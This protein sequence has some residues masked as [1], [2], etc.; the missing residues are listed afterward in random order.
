MTCTPVSFTYTFEPLPTGWVNL[1]EVDDVLRIENCP[2][3]FVAGGIPSKETGSHYA[4]ADLSSFANK[5]PGYGKTVFVGE[6]LAVRVGAMNQPSL[7]KYIRT[8]GAAA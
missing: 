3:I 8:N 5:I 4:T 1:Y 6:E 7:T 2:G